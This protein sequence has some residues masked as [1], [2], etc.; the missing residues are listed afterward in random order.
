[1][2]DRLYEQLVRYHAA[3]IDVAHRHETEEERVQRIRWVADAVPAAC[4]AFPL[5][6]KLGWTFEQ[7]VAMAAT[8][9]Q[10]ESALAKEVHAGTKTGPAGE[11]CLFQLHRNISSVPDERYRVT[12]EERLAT[13]G[14]DAEATYRCAFAGVRTIAWQV[15]RCRLRAGDF[16]SAAAAFSLYHHPDEHCDYVLSGMPAKRAASYRHLLE[17]IK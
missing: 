16:T 3:R 14:L 13:V 11:L 10:W 8:M 7:C 5:D 1:M 6:P 12:V 2:A 17:R 15:H 4:V 9:A